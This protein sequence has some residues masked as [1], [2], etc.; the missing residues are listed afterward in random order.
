[1]TNSPESVKEQA[2]SVESEVEHLH[3][4]VNWFKIAQWI[5]ILMALNLIG[6]VIFFARGLQREASAQIWQAYHRWGNV[7]R[8]AFLPLLW[9]VPLIIYREPLTALWFTFFTDLSHVLHFP[10]LVKFGAITLFPPVPMN[11][12]FRWFLA[13]PLASLLACVLEL[14]QPLTIKSFMRVLTPE[15]KAQLANPEAKQPHTTTIEKQP[16]APSEAKTSDALPSSASPQ[17][18]AKS[19][20]Q[21]KKTTAAHDR[22]EALSPR[23]RTSSQEKARQQRDTPI[24]V[25]ATPPNRSGSA[26]APSAHRY[27]WDEGEGIIDV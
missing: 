22:P 17:K 27:T 9:Y 2:T 7:R 5:V 23:P 19:T 6:P 3:I 15:E 18:T 10:S 20:A 1:M 12:L 16:D 14:L 8:T 13:L 11:T 4:H 26:L 25:P 21:R 24:I